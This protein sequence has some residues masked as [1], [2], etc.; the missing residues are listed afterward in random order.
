MGLVTCKDQAGTLIV[1]RR[2][3]VMVV[4]DLLCAQQQSYENSFYARYTSRIFSRQK[5]I[6]YGHCFTRRAVQ[7][8]GPIIPSMQAHRAKAGGVHAKRGHNSSC[9][10]IVLQTQV[11]QLVKCR[12]NGSILVGGNCQGIQTYDGL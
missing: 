2:R 3:Q 5:S 1:C 4:G 12:H 7:K 8:T 11:M 6:V 9:T 10:Q